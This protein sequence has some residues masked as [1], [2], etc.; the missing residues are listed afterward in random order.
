M[1]R[2][3]QL[4]DRVRVYSADEEEVY[5][6]R[7]GAIV[8]VNGQNGWLEIKFD[9]PETEKIP[10]YGHAHHKQCRRLVKKKWREFL[11]HT[12]M[13]RDGLETCRGC[14][15]DEHLRVREVKP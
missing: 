13:H 7:D 2:P 15:R 5:R 9:R 14:S 3:F 1:K 8:R 6:E 12:Q 4:G 11:L 10:L